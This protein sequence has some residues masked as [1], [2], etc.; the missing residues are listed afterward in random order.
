MNLF[1]KEYPPVVLGHCFHE[2]YFQRGLYYL[3]DSIFQIFEENT[4][5]KIDW[6]KYL[7]NIPPTHN[8][9]PLSDYLPHNTHCDLYD[10]KSYEN[11]KDM[12][13]SVIDLQLY[14]I[15]SS[16]KAIA[17]KYSDW[18]TCSIACKYISA[19]NLLYYP[20]YHP[21]VGFGLLQLSQATWNDGESF[22]AQKY[23]NLAKNVFFCTHPVNNP[24]ND[25]L[26]QIL[27]SFETDIEKEITSMQ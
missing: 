14:T 26:W 11:L 6:P 4:S 3:T 21:M 19:I 24:S 9:T 15:V 17:T 25:P 8:Y 5:Q 20:K 16:I 27:N 10:M 1:V 23:L 22:L 7:K 12:N 13:I 18:R 2:L